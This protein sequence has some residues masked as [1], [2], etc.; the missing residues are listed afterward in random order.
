[1]TIFL[2][3]RDKKVEDAKFSTDGCLFTIA[4][5]EAVAR[6][7]HGKTAIECLRINQ[8][9]ILGCLQGVPEDHEHCALLA[10][11]AFQKA[12]KECVIGGK[13]SA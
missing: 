9:A 6:M 2:R 3:V 10:A 1:M 5:S 8:S 13:E 11:M 12:L 4:A 7:A